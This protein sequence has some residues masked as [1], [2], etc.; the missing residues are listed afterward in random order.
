MN[1]PE[2]KGLA[3][4]RAWL[5]DHGV[6]D[7]EIDAAIASGQLH[8]LVA[9]RMVVPEEPCYTS[10]EVAD[11]TGLPE[12]QVRRLW[13]ALGFPDVEPGEQ[14]FTERD[15]AALTSVHGLIYLGLSDE[16]QMVQQTRVIGSSMARITAAQVDASPVMRGNTSSL[17]LAELYV[18]AADAIVP[19]M[20]RLL[21]Y[22]WRR[23]MQATMRRAALQREAQAEAG[24]EPQ[25][26]IGFADLV[27]FTSLSQQLSGG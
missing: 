27:G 10:A 20:A 4:V 22:A 2:P 11:L 5:H 26:A 3:G 15:V 12:E 24:D 13:R 19:D 18:L 14:A 6:D 23:H 16:D 8:V 1:Q 17:D 21:E 7:A 25:M 9:D